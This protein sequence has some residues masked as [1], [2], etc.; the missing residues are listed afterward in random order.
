MQQN[1]TQLTAGP[2][3][4]YS[5]RTSSNAAALV[6][7]VMDPLTARVCRLALPDDT[8]AHGTAITRLI[9]KQQYTWSVD[10]KPAVATDFPYPEIPSTVGGGATPLLTD[11]RDFPVILLRD[12]IVRYITREKRPLTVP[13]QSTYSVLFSAPPLYQVTTVPQV[14]PISYLTPVMGWQAYGDRCPGGSVGTDRVFWLDACVDLPAVIGMTINMIASG[15]ATLKASL[16]RHTSLTSKSE[17]GSLTIVNTVPNSFSSVIYSGYY[18]IVLTSASLTVF[19]SSNITLTVSTNSVYRHHMPPHVFDH[20]K[21][22]DYTRILGAS[23]LL[24]NTAPDWQRGGTVTGAQVNGDVMW[25]E[26]LADPTL[27]Y[28][29]NLKLQQTNDYKNG[30]YTY[31]KPTATEERA[32]GPFGLLKVFEHV[33]ESTELLPNFKPFEQEGFVICRISPPA[34]VALANPDIASAAVFLTVTTLMEFVTTDQ[35]F[36]VETPFNTPMEYFE[37]LRVLREAPQFF[38][39]PFHFSDITKFIGKALGFI[40]KHGPSVMKIAK[41]ASPWFA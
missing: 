23:L 3:A 22:I 28:D 40:E 33:A 39:N 2:V 15:T 1:Q 16:M 32:G 4:V 34:P 12:S 20:G 41:I 26:Y 35:F 25:Y 6:Q 21:S 14:L 38:D 30:M 31:F 9:N 10:R 17:V 29:V 27:I 5:A 37:F 24:T 11:E 18:S 13:Q 19:S 36:D 7:Q 8:T